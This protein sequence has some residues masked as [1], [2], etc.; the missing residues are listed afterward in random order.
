[1]HLQVSGRRLQNYGGSVTPKGLLAATLPAWLAALGARMA[2]DTAIFGC[3]QD[4]CG[5]S[6]VGDA[7]AALPNHVLVNAYAP[8]S[9]IMVRCPAGAPSMRPMQSMRAVYKLQ[10]DL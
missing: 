7:A 8:G 3:Q 10:M 2:R 4:S 6:G 1:M 9:G 5:Q